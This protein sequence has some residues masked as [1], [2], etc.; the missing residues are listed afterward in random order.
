MPGRKLLLLPALLN[1]GVLRGIVAGR[2][3]FISLLICWMA[4][5]S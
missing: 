1:S 4:S 2:S 5:S 3:G